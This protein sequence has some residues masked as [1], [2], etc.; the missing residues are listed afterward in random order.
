MPNT[1][2]FDGVELYYVS[3]GE[4]KPILFIHGWPCSHR[5]W[6]SQI[7]A[8]QNEFH[9][10]ALDL[11]GMGQ[12]EKADC[13]YT[14]KE[15][16]SDIRYLIR[17]LGLKDVTLVGWS[18]GVS[19]T[20]E[21]MSRFQDDG[22]VGRIVLIN[23]PIKLI[24]SDDWDFGIEEQECMQYINS[25]VEA[26]VNGRRSFAEANLLNPSESEVEFL[27]NISMQ[28]PLDIA[29]KAVTDQIYLDHREALKS[30]KVPCLAMQSDQDFYPVALG[31]YIADTVQKGSL[32]VFEGCG[33]SVQLQNHDR[34]NQA[35]RKF[36]LENQA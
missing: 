3:R 8:L 2:T 25:L 20:M 19:V 22:D 12:S 7:H 21:Y 28:T 6:D 30:V 14:F 27:F 18:M 9:C 29:M 34:F 23:G 24:K 15:F 32:H 1:T 36:I 31:Q 11:R 4:G 17:T 33:H 10:V 26:P 16:A 5:V 13:D 35:L